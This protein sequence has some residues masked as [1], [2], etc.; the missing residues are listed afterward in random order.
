M[1]ENKAQT[2]EKKAEEKKTS[3]K[4]EA[5]KTP[6]K[7][8]VE[9]KPE[10]KKE[11]KKEGRE[12]IIPLRRAVNRVP[13]YKRANKAVRT[14][15]EFIARHM[16]VADRDIKNVRLDIYLNESV[17]ARGIRNP[18]AK[19]KVRAVKDGD[20]VK[21]ELLELPGALKFKKEK[22]ERLQKAAEETKKAKPVEPKPEE[23]PEAE[24]TGAEITEEK[25]EKKEEAKEKKAAVI[26]AGQEMAKKAA[27][28][29]KHRTKISK[30][31]KHQFRKAL[32][33]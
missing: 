1:A 11:E 33:K 6:E 15:K 30:Q 8:K 32:S 7:S 10:T 23:K 19:I 13:R 12:Y 25:E 26:E 27:K 2:T 16:K 20:I 14:I 29:E 22:I 31:P 24:K 28:R 4:P 21:V 18:P 9:V 5:K 17:W 3:S